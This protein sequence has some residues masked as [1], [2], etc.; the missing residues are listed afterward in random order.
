MA[1]HADVPVLRDRRTGSVPGIL[2]NIAGIR[3]VGAA[4]RATTS[5]RSRLAPTSAR[6][7]GVVGT[8]P[9]LTS[10]SGARRHICIGCSRQSTT[11]SL[12]SRQLVYL[13]PDGRRYSFVQTVPCDSRQVRSGLDLMTAHLRTT[14]H[15]PN[16][17]VPVSRC[18]AGNRILGVAPSPAAVTA[19]TAVATGMHPSLSP[20]LCATRAGRACTGDGASLK[21][22]GRR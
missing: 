2:R 9:V 8:R 22:A 1:R 17:C 19:V 12:Q 16:A 21:S 18:A 4:D 13:S 14:K 3:S 6:R 20:C 7:P 5:G 10:R 11:A 15:D